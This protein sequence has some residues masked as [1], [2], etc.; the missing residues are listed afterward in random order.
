VSVERKEGCRFIA[1]LSLQYSPELS[2][3]CVCFW[4]LQLFSTLGN[5]MSVVTRSIQFNSFFHIEFWSEESMS[6]SGQRNAHQILAPNVFE[7]DIWGSIFLKILKNHV[8]L[9]NYLI[10]LLISECRWLFDVYRRKTGLRRKAVFHLSYSKYDNGWQSKC[11]LDYGPKL[12]ESSPED[13]FYEHCFF[14][15]TYNIILSARLILHDF[16]C[17]R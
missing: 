11:S 14:I 3:L 5:L 1:R 17:G 13:L 16:L 10:C 7:N 2:S 9:W 6:S 4:Y 8:F 12:L 15:L